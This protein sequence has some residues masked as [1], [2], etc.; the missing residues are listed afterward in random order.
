MNTEIKQSNEQLKMIGS[1]G[2]PISIGDVVLC[3]DDYLATVIDIVQDSDDTYYAVVTDQE[4][5]EFDL[6]YDNIEY[7]H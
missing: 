4:G 6:D 1:N 7:N 3:N 2:K 5:N